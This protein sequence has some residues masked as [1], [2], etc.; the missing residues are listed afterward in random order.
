MGGAPER[1]GCVREGQGYKE[2]QRGGRSVC[3]RVRGTG[4]H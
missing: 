4:E 3:M 1:R 2:H